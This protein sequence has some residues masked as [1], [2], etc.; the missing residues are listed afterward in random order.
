[1][2]VNKHALLAHQRYAHDVGVIYI[3]DD[4]NGRS[5]FN[6]VKITHDGGKT[7]CEKYTGEDCSP[8]NV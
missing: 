7:Q 3:N 1:M 8:A 6:I 5:L 4:P 2:V